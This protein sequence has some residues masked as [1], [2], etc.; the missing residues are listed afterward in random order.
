[1]DEYSEER[2]T[3]RGVVSHFENAISEARDNGRDDLVDELL[4]PAL[5]AQEQLDAL[6]GLVIEHVTINIPLDDLTE[7]SVQVLEQPGVSA[8]TR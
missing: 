1:M 3:L 2:E 5:H 7:R 6:D 4:D 8:T